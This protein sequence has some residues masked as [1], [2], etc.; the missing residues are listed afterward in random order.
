MIVDQ[1]VLITTK[2]PFKFE[3][4]TLAY[5]ENKIIKQVDAFINNPKSAITQVLEIDRDTFNTRLEEIMNEA[6]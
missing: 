5:E 1:N 4:Y 2:T 3:H 6:Y